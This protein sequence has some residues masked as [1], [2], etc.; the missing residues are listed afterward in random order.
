MGLKSW[1]CQRDLCQ[2]K[3]IRQCHCAKYIE[4]IREKKTNHMELTFGNLKMLVIIL[5][6]SI[7]Q[8]IQNCNSQNTN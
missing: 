1:C 8:M 2:N 5:V 4:M 7:I 3:V 6:S